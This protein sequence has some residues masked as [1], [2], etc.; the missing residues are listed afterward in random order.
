M[1]KLVSLTCHSLQ[2]LKKTQARL[3]LRS[4]FLA[5]SLWWNFKHFS[6][7]RREI[8]RRHTSCQQIMTSLTFIRF[9]T[10]LELSGNGIPDARF[11]Y[12]RFSSIRIFYLAKA[13]SRTKQSPTQLSY[14]W[15]EEK[16][17]FCQE[18]ADFLQNMLISAKFRESWCYK[19]YFLKLHDCL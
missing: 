16:Y 17:Y 5:R 4:D 8:R 13:G 9:V 3:I 14:Y 7:L 1:L 2:I 10:N 12:L 11:I 6:N 18:N 15:F 19:V